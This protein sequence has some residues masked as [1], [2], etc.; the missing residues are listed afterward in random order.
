MATIKEWEKDLETKS[1]IELLE[2]H[3][4]LKTLKDWP[5]FDREFSIS[6]L[7]VVVKIAIDNLSKP[8]RRA[9]FGES[10]GR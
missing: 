9:S 6:I 2:I 10:G 8:A 7:R 5:M 3:L 1:D 4:A